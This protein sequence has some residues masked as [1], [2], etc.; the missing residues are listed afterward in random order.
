MRNAILLAAGVL[1][2]DEW[3][4]V[5]RENAI[6]VQRMF[7]GLAERGGVAFWYNEL[8]MQGARS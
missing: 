6:A 5:P 3:R 1:N 7:V 2:R 8:G 4:N